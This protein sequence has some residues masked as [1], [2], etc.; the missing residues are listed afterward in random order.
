MS[1]TEEIMIEM[2]KNEKSAETVF[3]KY[4]RVAHSNLDGSFEV[5]IK[6]NWYTCRYEDNFVLNAE[7]EV[8]GSV[9]YEN[10]CESI[11]VS[12]MDAREKETT[13]AY[14]IE[15]SKEEEGKEPL[16]KAVWKN[17]YGD[18]LT[19]DIYSEE[20]KAYLEKYYAD[21][22]YTFIPLQEQEVKEQEVKEQESKT[23][24]GEYDVTYKFDGEEETMM[25]KG[26]SLDHVLD[27]LDAFY[28]GIEI[29]R[30]ECV[31]APASQ[32]Q[33]VKEQESSIVLAFKEW[34][35][36][37]QIDHK[38][39][40]ANTTEGIQSA[41][42]YATCFI[43][44]DFYESYLLFK[45]DRHGNFDL[46]HKMHA[47]EKEQKD[48]N[49]Q[50]Q[51]VKAE[52]QYRIVINKTVVYMDTDFTRAEGHFNALKTQTSGHM[53]LLKNGLPIRERKSLV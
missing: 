43:G 3:K 52:D 50:E 14:R 44:R 47:Y 31:K 37:M 17:Y 38:H 2:F 53:F 41:K 15:Q 1:H 12:R 28:T 40:F 19:K 39:R 21:Y 34:T 32:E 48:P 36:D 20:Y 33:E 45:R 29:T 7:G 9:F 4:V 35:G 11:L 51:E 24:E 18:D 26:I 27:T 49:S 13:I 5:K 10:G 30:I 16:Y 46:V 8:I 23:G 25:I 6:G 42:D 22:E